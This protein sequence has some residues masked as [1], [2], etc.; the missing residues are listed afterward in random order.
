MALGVEQ[1]QSPQDTPI[2]QT[3]PCLGM[4]QSRYT[5]AGTG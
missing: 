2:E 5:V 4:E 1:N 3:P